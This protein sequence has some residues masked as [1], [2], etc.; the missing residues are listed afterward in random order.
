MAI[1]VEMPKLGNTVEECLV[2]R[3]FKKPGEAV[4]DGEVLAEIET[5]KATFE[6]TAPAAGTLLGIFFEEGDLVPIFANVCVVGKSGESIEEF[7]P[8]PAASIPETEMPS[9]V[10]VTRRHASA[11]TPSPEIAQTTEVPGQAA[12]SPRARRF[13]EERGLR[14]EKIMGTGPGGRI[15]EADLKR[16]YY[17]SPRLSSLAEKMVE[18]GFELRGDASV[19]KRRIF[20]GDLS[21]PPVKISGIREKIARRMRASLAETAQYTMNTSADATG[22]LSLRARIKAKELQADS[23]SVNI[24]DMIMFCAIRALEAVPEMNVEF[25]DGKIYQHSGIHIG[26]ACDTPKGLLVPVIRDSQKLGLMELASKIKALTKQAVE[27]GIAPDDLSGGSFTV[28]NLGTYGIESFSPI[29]NPP[30]VAILGVDAIGLKPVRRKGA[31]EFIDHIGLSLTCDHQVIDGAHG[32]RFLKIV[33]ETIEDV[34]SI[35]GIGG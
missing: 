27:G 30:Q 20:S 21:S 14:P 6:L 11:G 29:L 1:P 32:A 33:R 16:L 31:V 35:A 2:A 28:S 8:K 3:W 25:L 24:N 4:A 13:A 18:S 22:L 12:F 17:E 5:D 9:G 19:A 34:E 23:P 15:L 10:A 7:K 26:F